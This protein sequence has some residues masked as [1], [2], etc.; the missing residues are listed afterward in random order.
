MSCWTSHFIS[1]FGLSPS[2][3]SSASFVSAS[4]SVRQ[5]E[6]GLLG[7]PSSSYSFIQKMSILSNLF[8][9]AHPRTTTTKSLP[10]SSLTE[11]IHLRIQFWNQGE[12][13]YDLLSISSTE[14]LILSRLSWMHK[15]WEW[16]FSFYIPKESF[17][18]FS[19]WEML[20]WKRLSK[21][22]IRF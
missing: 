20:T 22:F 13:F 21:I 18:F 12:F 10:A 3:W 11:S 4:Q 5:R 17:F 9:N 16:I 2:C 6:L 15:G 7:T 8:P 19:C 14:K 1:Y